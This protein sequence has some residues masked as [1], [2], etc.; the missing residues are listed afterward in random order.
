LE[1]LAVVF[2]NPEQL[3]LRQLP[4]ASATDSD[5]VVN[6]DWTS[7]SVGTERLLWT[8]R[9]P[10]FPGLGYPLVPGY[11]AVGRVSFAGTA[12]GHREGD[13]VFVPGANCYGDVRGLFG[14]AA[15][16][17]VVPGA[18]ALNV[19][20][21][22]GE[23]AV[24]LALAATAYHAL[25]GPRATE[26]PDLVIGHGTFGRLTARLVSI[27]GN[28]PCTVWEKDPIRAA[29]AL[30][31]TVTTAEQ[32]PR[33]D[34]KCIFDASGDASLIEPMIMRLAKGGE[35]VLAGF[36]SDPIAFRFPMAFMKEAR[37][38][39]AAE[40]DPADLAAVTKLVVER[41]LSFDGLIT[42]EQPASNA[43]D[44]YEI[45]FNDPSCVKMILDWRESA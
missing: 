44:A 15:S 39:I 37:L 1:A 14:G 31:Y 32:D 18:R 36:Y 26:M 45:A 35:I 20:D 19:D 41:K 4:I 9:M 13:R 29:G 40:W 42:H 10:P 17:V 11:E 23:R 6:V 5:V 3:S 22:L 12:S 25:K 21:S 43:K 8:G 24:L 33:R 2:D 28:A 38:R 34:Y 27:L 16:R 7:I 30:G